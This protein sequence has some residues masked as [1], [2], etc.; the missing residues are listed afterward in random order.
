M[1]IL[2]TGAEGIVGNA[3]LSRYG[4]KYEVVP[5]DIKSGRDINNFDQLLLLA[6][7][8]DRILHLAAIPKPKSGC[9]FSDYLKVNCLGTQNVCKVAERLKIKRIVFSSS[10]TYYGIEK[11]IPFSTPITENKAILSQYI[12]ASELECR[13]IDLFY[14]HSKVIAEQIIAS[15][16]LSK[17]FE[18]IILRLAPVNKVFLNTSVSFENASQAIDL[19]IKAE[20]EFWNEAFSI[21][22]PD[23]S[24]I[25]H[26]KATKL[27]GYTPS[28]PEYSPSQIH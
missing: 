7:G 5:Y 25:S 24:H 1:K 26:D 8:C 4:E 18:A 11:G 20:G 2:V 16:S 10:T 21:V 3:F 23:L 6:E 27:L 9:D 15:Y 28:K 22:D 14:H 12:K 17:K 13:D 19:A